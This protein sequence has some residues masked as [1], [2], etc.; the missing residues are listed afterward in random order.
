MTIAFATEKQHV[1]FI[2]TAYLLLSLFYFLYLL[3]NPLPHSIVLYLP[4]P[5]S[6]SI[7]NPSPFY[8]PLSPYTFFYLHY[9]PPHSI[10]LYLHL[11]PSTFLYLPHKNPPYKKTGC[12][13]I[14]G[15]ARSNY[16]RSL[17]LVLSFRI[18]VRRNRRHACHRRRSRHVRHVRRACQDRP[19]AFPRAPVGRRIC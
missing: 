4:L 12:T 5:S 15:T 6:I 1:S 2:F 3:I 16:F 8:C 9:N 10:V 19:P 7:I 18:E 13:R 17:V 11:P 14:S